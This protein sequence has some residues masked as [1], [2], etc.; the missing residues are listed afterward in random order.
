[1]TDHQ[2]QANENRRIIDDSGLTY[3]TNNFCGLKLM[4]REK[5]KPPIDFRPDTGC[6]RIASRP[7]NHL[8]SGGAVKFLKWYAKQ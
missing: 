8:F 4:I 5:D 2:K 7:T 3:T 1:M 6:W